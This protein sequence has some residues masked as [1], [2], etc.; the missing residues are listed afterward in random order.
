MESYLGRQEDRR[1]VGAEDQDPGHGM[2]TS[3][4]K[5]SRMALVSAVG[6]V[7]DSDYEIGTV[8]HWSSQHLRGHSPRK[9]KE[10]AAGDLSLDT[11]P[12]CMAGSSY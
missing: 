11:L 3:I 6:L 2:E 9:Y 12:D 4:E 1:L 10:T 7:V 5:Y 8:K